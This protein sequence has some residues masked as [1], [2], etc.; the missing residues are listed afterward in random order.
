[1]HEYAKGANMI[2]QEKHTLTGR[3]APMTIGHEISGVVDEVGPDVEGLKVGDRVAIQPI[4]P[5]KTCYAC[6]Q[7]RPN[8]CAKQGFYGLSKFIRLL[9]RHCSSIRA[10]VRVCLGADGGLA[11]Y[12]VVGSQNAR[13]VPSNVTLEVAGRDLVH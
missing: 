6:Q 10:N 8:C 13:K 7:N 12:V 9:Y 11:D 5:D 1:M 3:S 4:I 2:P